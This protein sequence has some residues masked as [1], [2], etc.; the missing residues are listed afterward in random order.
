MGRDKDCLLGELVDYDQD[1]VKPGGYRKFLNEVHRNGILWSFRDGK[2]FERSV[3]LVM[4]WLGLH[5]SDT[6]LAEL[7]Y[8]STE[9]GPGISTA[10]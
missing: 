9:A 6:G 1:S 7:L 3:G 8:I 2:L 10:D 5:T 4:L